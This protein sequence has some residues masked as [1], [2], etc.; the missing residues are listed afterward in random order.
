MVFFYVSNIFY[1]TIFHVIFFGNLDAKMN[2]DISS[3]LDTILL[4]R[5]DPTA[6]LIE[7]DRVLCYVGSNTHLFLRST[8]VGMSD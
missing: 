1:V 3:K 8:R 5:L 2:L 7:F 4:S 6:I